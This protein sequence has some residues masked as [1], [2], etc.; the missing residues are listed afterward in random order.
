MGFES[1]EQLPPLEGKLYGSRDLGCIL[2]T[3][4]RAWCVAAR[5]HVS[6][7]LMGR[8]LQLNYEDT[9]LF[10]EVFG[11]YPVAIEGFLWGIW[12]RW[13]VVSKCN[14][15]SGIDGVEL[16]FSSVYLKSGSGAAGLGSAH[17]FAFLASCQAVLLALVTSLLVARGERK[18]SF[19]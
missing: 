5:Q 12:Q 14:S 9:L 3:C 13:S 1:W 15:T 19:Q 10:A 18:G 2:A 7:D 17:W 8:L 4:Q 16:S 6:I 11:L